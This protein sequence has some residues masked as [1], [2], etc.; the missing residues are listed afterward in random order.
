MK[1]SNIIILVGAIVILF[2]VFAPSIADTH[3]PFMISTVTTVHTYY[4]DGTASVSSQDVNWGSTVTLSLDITSTNSTSVQML[5]N[6]V[7]VKS[8][9]GSVT[10]IKSGLYTDTT[11]VKADLTYEARYVSETA[12]GI[13]GGGTY[14]TTIY[15][16]TVTMVPLAKAP[17]INSFILTPNP[18][19]LG[20]LVTPSYSITSYGNSYTTY[21]LFLSNEYTKPFTPEKDGNYTVTLHATDSYG[22]TSSSILLKVYTPSIENF[23]AGNFYYNGNK[24][25][26]Q[27]IFVNGT[28]AYLSFHY[29]G[30]GT[31]ELILGGEV[32]EFQNNNLT[33]YVS[34]NYTGTFE[35]INN[36][37]TY[38]QSVDNIQVYVLAVVEGSGH[39]FN[40]YGEYEYIGLGV[41]FVIIG[42]LI[43]KRGI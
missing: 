12:S 5:V 17:L 25:S 38:T 24:L 33:I 3:P 8:L 13:I 41:V 35:V 42:L 29:V 36:G 9:S 10:P 20:N 23:T 34:G 39:V 18:V 19:I 16:T 28:S 37:T 30:N 32:Y 27:S 31:A 4:F 7:L 43:K 22:T 40:G 14:Y 15:S 11:I 21:V 2:G 6:G 26:D 1:I